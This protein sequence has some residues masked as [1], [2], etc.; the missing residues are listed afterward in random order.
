MGEVAII[1][2]L[3]ERVIFYSKIWANFAGTERQNLERLEPT[4]YT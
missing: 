1:Q 3:E 4:Y 2:H